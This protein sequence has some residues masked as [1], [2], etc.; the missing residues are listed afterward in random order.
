MHFS[1]SQFNGA[2]TYNPPQPQA[3]AE[4]RSRAPALLACTE[5]R[6]RH[7]KC[8]AAQ[9]VCGRCTS[10]QRQ[11]RYVQS[12]R[13]YK[14]PR[15]RP[16]SFAFDIPMGE[17]NDQL[18]QFRGPPAPASSFQDPSLSAQQ[19]ATLVMPT[20]SFAMPLSRR[21]SDSNLGQ[22]IEFPSPPETERSDNRDNAHYNEMPQNALNFPRNIL[23]P[24]S[25]NAD[26]TH[27][28][29]LYYVHFHDAH[30]ILLPRKYFPKHNR[31]RQYPNHLEI[32]MQFIGS[33][34]D[35]AA[36]T[37]EYRNLANEV[38]SDQV[39]K[40]GSKVQ[41]LL[42]LAIS[43]HA[44]DEQKLAK[45]ILGTAVDI[46]LD[47]GMHRKEFSSERGEGCRS[48][49]ESWRRTWWELYVMDGML[50]ALNQ[51]NSFK[52]FNIETNVPLPCEEAVYQA[53]DVR[54]TICS[55][56]NANGYLTVQIYSRTSCNEPISESCFCKS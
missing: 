23:F 36:P 7:L 31:Y 52:L 1:P 28:F 10:D 19:H 46:A 55:L 54:I 33:H 45:E 44:R 3:N 14:G 18:E 51:L 15:K 34:Y 17:R 26:S 29:N 13:G 41:S 42:L 30:P 21:Q 9:P 56:G 5:C 8:D 2:N 6:T 4:V 38:L 32:I 35:E 37:E 27:V 53:A 40:D 48:L 24:D 11:C 25:N 43:L 39:P 47:L 50:A 22:R 20:N 49:Q 12:R 16:F